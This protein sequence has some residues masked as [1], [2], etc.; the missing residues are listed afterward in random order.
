[1]SKCTY[2]HILFIGVPPRALD[3][4]KNEHHTKSSPLYVLGVDYCELHLVPEVVD[5]CE[6]NNIEILKTTFYH[7]TELYFS[8]DEIFLMFKM[9]FL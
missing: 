7:H 2:R 6:A 8:D 4:S 5:F 3:L 1:M 9:R